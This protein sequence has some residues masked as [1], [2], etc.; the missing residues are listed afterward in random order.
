[1]KNLEKP[2]FEFPPRNENRTTK[3][4]N[5]MLRN[6]EMGIVK[7]KRSNKLE[8]ILDLDILKTITRRPPRG[9]YRAPGDS[10]KITIIHQCLCDD[11]V[12]YGDAYK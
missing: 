4:S 2:R 11:S 9:N 3:R 8:R 1:M 10:S 7:V 5:R 12:N 6:C